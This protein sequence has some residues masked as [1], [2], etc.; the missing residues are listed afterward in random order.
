MVVCFTRAFVLKKTDLHII[1]FQV[2]YSIFYDD[3]CYSKIFKNKYTL[4]P[5]GNFIPVLPQPMVP[6]PL[7]PTRRICAPL[8]S[9]FKMFSLPFSKYV[10]QSPWNS[11]D[12]T[13]LEIGSTRFFACNIFSFFKD[14][15]SSSGRFLD[16]LIPILLGGSFLSLFTLVK[17]SS[18]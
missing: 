15:V 9:T 5:I 1:C 6:V 13:I 14:F 4:N 18:K 8:N 2:T 17:C 16:L 10:D 11:L 3:I 12:F 7:P